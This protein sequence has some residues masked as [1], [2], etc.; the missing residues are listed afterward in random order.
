MS[1]RHFAI[2]MLIVA[3]ALALGGCKKKPPEGAGAG[4]GGETKAEPPQKTEPSAA[5]K[6][7]D[8]KKP[9]AGC[10]LATP[11]KSQ[12]TLTKGCALSVS[13]GIQI[14]EGGTLTI[15][16]GVKL[17]FGPEG[18]LWVNHGR[19]AAKGTKEAPIT[20][21]ST[22]KTPAAGDWAGVGFDASTQAGT[23]LDWVVLEH[24]GRDAHGFK[25][26]IE[27]RGEKIGKH[28]SITNTVIRK[29]EQA[30]LHAPAIGSE[31]AR[32]ENNTFDGCKIA[33]RVNANVLGSLGAGNKL[34][35]PVEIEGNVTATQSWPAI[36]GAIHVIEHLTVGG[37][38]S[39]AILT[40]PEKATLKFPMDGYLQVGA[41]QGG[42]LVAK[43]VTFTSANAAPADGDWV[44]L[45]FEDK[46]TG[47]NL[48]GCTIAYAGRDAHGGLAAIT[49][50]AK[51]GG[52]VKIANTTFKGTKRAAIHAPEGDCG[53]LAKP[54]SGNKVEGVPLC[55]KVE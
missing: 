14:E 15:E 49:L 21:T 33:M 41:D 24:A 4:A 13:E 45:F 37:E 28:I 5:A 42:G 38:K 23:A 43:N 36:D 47:V 31:L 53:E 48:D 46:A 50:R 51:P 29:A 26:A 25:G 34:G 19:L 6:K 27:V 16:P 1:T 54:A 8:E 52:G 10:A 17:S 32:F 20:L 39:A 7:E 11:I 35:A 44:G 30:G 40:L 55:A 18:Y 22:S 3:V 12:V 9:S 2:S